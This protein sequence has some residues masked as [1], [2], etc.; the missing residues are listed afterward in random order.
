MRAGRWRALG[1][2]RL[3][4]VIGWHLVPVERLARLLDWLPQKFERL[5]ELAAELVR[6]KVDVIVTTGS[7]MSVAKKA[8]VTIPIASTIATTTAR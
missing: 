6:L 7:A 5:P 1:L 4:F 3:R 2:G 8:S